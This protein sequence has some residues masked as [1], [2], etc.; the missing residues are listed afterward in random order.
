MTKNTVFKFSE[1]D[2]IKNLKKIDGW[3]V[4]DDLLSIFKTYIFKNFKEAFSWMTS[5]SIEAERLD[6]HPEWSNV[7]NKVTVNLST[8]DVSGLSKKDIELASF[9]DQ[10]F[11]KW[12]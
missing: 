4:K 1:E 2:I 12:Q 5:V 9:M 3:T 7:Y 10:E 8:H 11:K 6:H